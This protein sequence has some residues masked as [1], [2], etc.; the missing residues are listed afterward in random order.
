MRRLMDIA[1]KIIVH[2]YG[3]AHRSHTHSPFSDPVMIE[4]FCHQSMSHP[5]TAAGTVVHHG[6]V[7]SGG[8]FEYVFHNIFPGN[9]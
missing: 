1:V 3:A 9:R 6:I 4:G 8:L 7:E 5:V 2:E